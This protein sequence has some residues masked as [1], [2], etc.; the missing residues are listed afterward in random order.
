MK[1]VITT[2]VVLALAF[3]CWPALPG[4]VR[5]SI[6]AAVLRFIWPLVAI[7]VAVFAAAVMSFNGLTI[8]VL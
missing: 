4:D 2:F 6:K 8:Q 7:F 1:L 3:I 5:G